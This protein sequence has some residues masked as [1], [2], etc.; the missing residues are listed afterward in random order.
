MRVD[1]GNMDIPNVSAGE[2][3]HETGESGFGRYGSIGGFGGQSYSDERGYSSASEEHVV[4]R[5]E[6]VHEASHETS[7][8]T[9]ASNYAHETHEAEQTIFPPVSGVTSHPSETANPVTKDGLG[10]ENAP[11]QG[12]TETD[13][14]LNELLNR[15]KTKRDKK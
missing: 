7:G 6:V 9:S 2:S 10:G 8:P 12:Y 4:E 13:E 1:V 11:S 5:T 14:L 15:S 3:Y